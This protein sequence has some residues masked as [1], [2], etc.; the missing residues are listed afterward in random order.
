MEYT[1][2]GQTDLRVSR[3]AFGRPDP[4]TPFEKTRKIDALQPP[5]HL[6]RRD[7]EEL[8]QLAIAP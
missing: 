3:I 4:H 5:Y 7:A 1:R 8:G 2:L 6:F